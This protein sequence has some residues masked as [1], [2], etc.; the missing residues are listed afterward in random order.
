MVGSRQRFAAASR[1]DFLKTLGVGMLCLSLPSCNSLSSQGGDR[2]LSG[3]KPLRGIFPI[4]QTPFTESNKLDVNALVEEVKFI[5]RGRVPG[6]VWPQSASEWT[7][8]SEPERFEGM[9]A[10][11]ST[12]RKLRPAIVLGVQGPDLAAAQRY[13]KHAEKVGADAIISFPLP[14]GTDSKAMLEY[15]QQ[16]G[17]TTDLPLFVQ[18]SGN[19]SVDLLIEMYKTIPTMRYV[20]DDNIDPIPRIAALRE[21]SSDQLKVFT[22]AHGRRLMQEMPLGFSGNMPAASLADL[23]AVTWNLWHA[24]KHAEAQVMHERTLKALDEML[25]YGTEGLKYV[26]C[27][28]G[29]FKTYTARGDA[30]KGTLAAAATSMLSALTGRPPFDDKAKQSLNEMVKSLRPYLRA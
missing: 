28:R 14:K 6:F 27:I 25:L 30:T 11:G 18:P 3:P 24:G 12:G 15:Y 21:K 7:T 5:D 17:R 26:L 13:S 9:E 22:G 19:A 23:L 20:K 1:R 8:L 16:I 29:V 4:A 10:I 2:S